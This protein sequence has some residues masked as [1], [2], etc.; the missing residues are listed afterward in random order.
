MLSN[1]MNARYG[2]TFIE[3][4]VKAHQRVHI[5]LKPSD[6]EGSGKAFLINDELIQHQEI[7][8]V[9]NPMHL[10]KHCMEILLLKKLWKPSCPRIW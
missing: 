2:G 8:I 10:K 5:G 9:R 1:V 3:F 4:S 6:W 7:Q